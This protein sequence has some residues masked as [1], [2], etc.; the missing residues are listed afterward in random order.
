MYICGERFRKVMKKYNKKKSIQSIAQEPA[1]AYDMMHTGYNAIAALSYNDN[2]GYLHIIKDGVDASV[3]KDF[4][5]LSNI[6]IDLMADI[7]H[8]NSRTL[9]RIGEQDL[10][11]SHI[12][13]KLVELI[14]LYKLGHEVFGDVIVFNTWM[15]R[16]IK[17]LGYTRPLDIIDSSIGIDIVTEELQRIMYGVYS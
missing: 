1:I 5:K 13:E 6:H 8:L 9:R 3:L 14:R 16:K 10:L 4:M 11:N 15:D 12:S 7:L 17:G 2:Y